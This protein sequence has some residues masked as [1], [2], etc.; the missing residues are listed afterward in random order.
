MTQRPP[1]ASSHGGTSLWNEVFTRV[2][3]GLPD[4]SPWIFRVPLRSR[5]FLS[6]TVTITIVLGLVIAYAP[7]WLL[8][9]DEPVSMWVRSTVDP[10]VARIVTLLGSPNLSLVIGVVGVAVLWRWCRASAVTVGALLAS[11]FIVD[12]ALKLVVDRPRPPNTLVGTALGSFP[13]GHVIHAV[14]LFGLVPMLL[15]VV[16]YRRSVLRLGFAVFAVGVLVVAISRV[17]LGAHWPSHVIVSLFIGLSL[18]LSAEKLLTSPWTTGRCSG[19]NLHAFDHHQESGAESCDI[20][21][22]SAPDS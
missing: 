17:S 7:Q 12:I 15:W 11:A 19:A 3:L 13:S 18:L 1:T 14:V 10:D 20:S 22:E 16:T 4:D 8:W 5:A 9:F 6:V 2:H 21:L